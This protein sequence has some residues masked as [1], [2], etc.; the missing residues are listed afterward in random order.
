MATRG[1]PLI[2]LERADRDVLAAL[3]Y[4]LL[5]APDYAEPF[6]EAL[7]KAFRHIQRAP[8]SGSPRYAHALNIP[9]LRSWL[10]GRYPYVVFYMEHADRI[11][12]WRVLHTRQDIPAWL[13]ERDEMG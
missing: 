11:D 12:I 4:Y 9:G 10:C 3:D 6:L 2:R 1:K 13:E 7:E 8:A 5:E